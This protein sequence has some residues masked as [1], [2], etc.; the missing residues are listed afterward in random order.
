M[1]NLFMRVAE[2][3]KGEGFSRSRCAS[4]ISIFRDA[5]KEERAEIKRLFE[6]QYAMAKSIDDVLWLNKQLSGMS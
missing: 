1:T 6:S 5:N 2:A 3:L 4:A